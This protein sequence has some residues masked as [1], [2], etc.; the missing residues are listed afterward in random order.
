MKARI[1]LVRQVIGHSKILEVREVNVEGNATGGAVNLGS[2]SLRAPQLLGK[3]LALILALAAGWFIWHLTAVAPMDPKGF[4]FLATLNVAV[5]LWM[6][7]LLDDYVVGL[8]LLLSWVVLDI[9]PSKVALAGFSESW[10]FVIGALGIG[11]AVNKTGLLYR[12]SVQVLSRIP[13][14]YYR[15]YSFFLLTSGLLLTPL[16]PTGKARTIIAVPVSQSISEASGFQQRSSG[17]AA[18]TLAALIGYSQMSFMFLT[19][20]EFCLIGW[21]LLPPSS[22]SEFGWMTWFMAALPAG[23]VVVLVVFAA[24]QYFFPLNSETKTD[25]SNRTTEVQ[26]KKLGPINSQEWIA[27]AIL[28][29][30]LIGWLTMSLH[31]INETWIALAAL[32]VFL[33]TGILDKQGF[34]SNLDW[35]LI[36][37]FGIVNSIATISSYLGLDQW[38]IGMVGPLFTSYSIGPLTFFSFTILLVCFAR[39]FVRKSVVVTFFTVTLVPLGQSIGIHPGVLLLIILMASECFFLPY[40]DGPYQIAYSSTQGLAFSHAQARKLLLAKCFAVFVAVIVSIPYWTWLG[41]IA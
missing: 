3:H 23:V 15:T 29:L 17:S 10:F 30:T 38:F 7:E 41:L 31:E 18:L 24:I 36:L 5:A 28:G 20:G 1:S 9:V 8:M 27:A 11:A 13:I 12:L 40:Q 22:K 2:A 4:Q 6:L 14:C 32:L 19:G 39:L 33:I 34:K 26:L 21:N 35:G 16:L 37:F 25:L